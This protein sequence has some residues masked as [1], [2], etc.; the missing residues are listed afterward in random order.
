LGT[1]IDIALKA[2]VDFN[3]IH[4]PQ[5]HIENIAR[6]RGG[7]IDEYA[8]ANSRA[9]IWRWKKSGIDLRALLNCMNKI[10]PYTHFVT[11]EP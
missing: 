1:F 9:C 7:S 4:R 5:I 8:M 11:K 10:K 2:D 6:I 3:F